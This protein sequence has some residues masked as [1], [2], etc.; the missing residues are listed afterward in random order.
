[1]EKNRTFIYK[2]DNHRMNGNDFNF[3]MPKMPN[4]PNYNYNYNYKFGEHNPP[5]LGV[6]IEDTEN[7]TG[8]KILNVEEGSAADKAG[9]KKDDIITEID[10]EKVNNVDDI[11]QQ[12]DE[13]DD[14]ESLKLKANRNNAE[15]N[16]EIKIPK[17]LNKADL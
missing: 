9:L 12:I 15:M 4:L 5:K 13:A 17:E 8:A 14:K 16:F 10:G 1:M 6:K 2:D 7:G 3:K 11:K